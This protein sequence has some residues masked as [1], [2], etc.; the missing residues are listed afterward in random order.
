MNCTI[1]GVLFYEVHTHFASF[2]EELPEKF[3]GSA[4]SV[5]MMGEAK[6]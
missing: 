4:S 1:C 5:S 2:R 6:C 3:A